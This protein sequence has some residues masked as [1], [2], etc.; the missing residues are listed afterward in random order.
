M[1]NL[2]FLGNVTH[3]GIRILGKQIKDNKEVFGG[4]IVDLE[5]D[6]RGLKAVAQG[7]VDR[8]FA[9]FTNDA[10]T[11]TLTVVNAAQEAHAVGEAGGSAPQADS[12]KRN[13]AFQKEVAKDK[14]AS[15]EKAQA[16]L[17]PPVQT[18]A[19]P[20]PA[21]VAAGQ[22]SAAEVAAAAAAAA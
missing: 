6:T 21:P 7:L 9:E 17:P 3:G 19:S 14:A 16:P 5:T 2:R 20:A 15:V 18:N 11:H 8:G 1:A 13:L 10:P 22:P 12:L 4:S